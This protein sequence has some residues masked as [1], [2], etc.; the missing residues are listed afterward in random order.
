MYNQVE[1]ANAVEYILYSVD[2]RTMIVTS[3]EHKNAQLT[4]GWSVEKPI[5]VYNTNNETTTILVEQLEEYINAGWYTEPVTKLYA[6][7]GREEYFVNSMVEAQC[8]VG[9]FKTYEEAHPIN[10]DDVYL[11]ARLINAE[12]ASNNTLDKQYVG[13]VVMNRLRS[14][15]WGNTLKGVIYAKG[16][17]ACTWNGSRNFRSTPPQDCIDIATAL[18][19]GE[20]YGVPSNVI[21]QAQFKQGSGVWKKV[22]SHYYCYR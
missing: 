16:Q 7:D 13:A 12:A 21:F 14:G 15:Y 18:L 3:E 4:V 19:K 6:A 17:Y 20:T 11:L 10:Y 9:W 2:G 1:N 5:V 8:T 22:G